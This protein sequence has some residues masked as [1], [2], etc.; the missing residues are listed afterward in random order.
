MQN[1]KVLNSRE[2][3]EILKLINVQFG[4]SFDMDYEVFMNEKNKLFIMTKD[5]S[6]IDLNELRI[7][8]LGM[9]FG[10][11]NRGELRLSIEGSQ[12][13]GKSAKKNVLVLDEDD[14]DKWMKGEDFDVETGLCHN[15]E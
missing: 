11:V 5:I 15:K 7:N 9:Y 13:L 1:L 10:E 14:A 6:K 3:K 8:S 2:K 12:M 4:C